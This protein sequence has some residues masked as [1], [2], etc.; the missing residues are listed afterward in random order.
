MP[1]MYGDP[2]ATKVFTGPVFLISHGSTRK[3][4]R[5]ARILKRV[6]FADG[7]LL[8]PCALFATRVSGALCQTGQLAAPEEVHMQVKNC[9]AALCAAVDDQTVSILVYTTLLRD[10]VRCAR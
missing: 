4:R 6:N 10:P 3:T 2:K 1:I 9:L 7:A 5:F 8:A